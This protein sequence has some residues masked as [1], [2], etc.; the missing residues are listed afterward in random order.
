MTELKTKEECITE[1]EEIRTRMDEIL[2][3]LKKNPDKVET[4][5]AKLDD[6]LENLEKKVGY[7]KEEEI[8][9]CLK[10]F[11]I[12]PNIKG[13]A[14][15]KA[16]IE[17]CLDNP[18][19]IGMVTKRIYPAVATKYN[20]TA[21]RVEG[22]MR[23][24]I[25]GKLAK[26]SK[27]F[28]NKFFM[29]RENVTVSEFIAVIVEFLKE[30]DETTT[31][32]LHK[33]GISA[34]FKGYYYLKKAIIFTVESPNDSLQSIYSKVALEY[35]ATIQQVERNIRHAIEVS[36]SRSNHDFYVEIFGKEKSRKPTNS[37]YISAVAEYIKN[38]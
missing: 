23:A 29:D 14:Y 17:M 21:P 19:Y 18:S 4:V 26:A 7:G 15:L 1:F 13:Y 8:C 2:K 38:K 32:I 9:N 22:V 5:K 35:G 11:Q 3:N 28:R 36:N 25:K 24:T 20:T 31:E 30:D 33:L 27:E 37:E 34:N 12:Y 6:I 16:A 10:S